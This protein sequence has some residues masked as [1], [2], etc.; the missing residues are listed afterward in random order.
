MSRAGRPPKPTALKI[1]EG[2]PGGRKLNEDEPVFEITEQLFAERMPPNLGKF[3]VLEWKRLVKILDGQKVISD[4]YLNVMELYIST[5]D[6]WLEAEKYVKTHGPF[7]KDGKGKISANPA[8]KI[9][10]EASA[11]LLRIQPE[12]GLTPSSRTRIK[13]DKG[14]GKRKGKWSNEREARLFGRNK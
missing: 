2:N 7:I 5:Y 11:Q 10:R 13:V 8:L 1:L 12:L 4:A 3:A 14:V 6:T 9:S